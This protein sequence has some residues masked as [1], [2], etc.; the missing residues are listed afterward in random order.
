MFRFKNKKLYALFRSCLSLLLVFSLLAPTV[1]YANS[2]GSQ[3]GGS[4]QTRLDCKRMLQSNLS[5]FWFLGIST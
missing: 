4:N 1:V 3:G 5:P 2:G